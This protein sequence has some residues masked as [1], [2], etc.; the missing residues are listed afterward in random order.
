MSRR[1]FVALVGSAFAWPVTARAQRPALPIV[2]FMHSLSPEATLH[3][4]TAFRS[5]LSE[6]GF[7]EG[8]NISIEYRWARGNFDQLP[9]YAAELV[10]MGSAVIVAT[11]ST[12]SALAAKAATTKIPIVWRRGVGCRPPSHPTEHRRCTHD[13]AGCASVNQCGFAGGESSS[14][15]I[16]YSIVS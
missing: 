8:R 11:G 7:V 14:K 13:F 5:G 4:V 10:K 9:G 2:G 16:E 1:E 15:F 12:V 6:A 3:V